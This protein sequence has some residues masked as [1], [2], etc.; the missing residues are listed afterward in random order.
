MKSLAALIDHHDV[1]IDGR[2]YC[3]IS[4][5]RDKIEWDTRRTWFLV[6]VDH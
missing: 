6:Y 4:A 5:S 1:T 3:I 2:Q